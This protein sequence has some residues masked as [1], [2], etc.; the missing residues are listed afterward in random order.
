M[1]TEAAAA[2]EATVEE[3]LTP[4]Q[5]QAVANAAR[6]FASYGDVK[7]AMAK[8]AKAIV[9]LR[10][11]FEKDGR[12]DYR[13][14]TPQ[15]RGAIATLYE[16]AIPDPDERESFKVSIRYWVAKE[17]AAR[18]EDGRSK[19]TK[20]ALQEAGLMQERPA[21]TEPR[22]PRRAATPATAT[23]TG[24]IAE[25]KELSPSQ[26][27]VQA[28][29]V[30]EQHVADESLGVVMAVQSI[31]RELGPVVAALRDDAVRNKLPGKALTQ[32]VEQVLGLSLDAAHLAGIDIMEFSAAWFSHVMESATEVAA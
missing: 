28:E 9:N 5:K 25:G 22:E 24:V 6:A 21:P 16:N 30:V 11:T 8:I 19:I 12:P 31:G 15:Y 27:L 17:F 13:G 32:A 1:T 18:V 26:V 2:A 10:L 29:R 4:H 23:P 14:E 7:K 3:S 20:E